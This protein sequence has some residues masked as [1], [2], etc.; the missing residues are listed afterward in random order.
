MMEDA[1]FV[2][3]PITDQIITNDRVAAR[4]DD[5]AVAA[6][7]RDDDGGDDQDLPAMS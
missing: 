6:M 5:D 7:F 1:Q 2:R 4:A 3:A